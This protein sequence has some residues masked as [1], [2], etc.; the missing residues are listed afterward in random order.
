M[1]T[2][3]KFTNEADGVSATV[4][5][6]DTG[7]RR[8]VMRDEDADMVVDPITFFPPHHPAEAAE[9]YARELVFGPE[10]ITL[11]L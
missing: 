11:N 2:E 5:L 10:T 8:V 1:I 9:K 3:H 7:R 6:D 4:F